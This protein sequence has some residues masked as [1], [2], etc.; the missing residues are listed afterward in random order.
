MAK[1]NTSMRF[2][3][4][5]VGALLVVLAVNL[6]IDTGAVLHDVVCPDHGWFA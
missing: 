1:L 2:L 3:I 4:A 5:S 6:M